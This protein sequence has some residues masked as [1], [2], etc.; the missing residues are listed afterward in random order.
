MA[1]SLNSM[2]F[3]KNVGA[4]A[5]GRASKFVFLGDYIDRGPDSAAVV[6]TIMDMQVANPDRCHRPLRQSRRHVAVMRISMMRL[7]NG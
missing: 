6:Q 7:R 4:F 5:N 3:S 1:P 2:S